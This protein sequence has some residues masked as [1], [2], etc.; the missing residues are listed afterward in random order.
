M[1]VGAYPGTFDPPTVAHVAIAEAAWRQGGLDRVELVVCAS[2]LGKGSSGVAPLADRVRLLDAVCEPR[3]WL[4]WS[5]NDSQLI[6]DIADGYDAVILGSDKWAQVVDPQWYDGSK[7]VR[8]E[9]LRRL[10]RVLIAARGSDVLAR[11]PDTATVLEVDRRLAS[12]SATAVRS[13]RTDWL[14]PELAGG[15]APGAGGPGSAS[16]GGASQGAGRP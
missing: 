12:V 8:D 9:A 3:P 15:W 1:R 2:P 14:A 11:L 4:G 10:P 6:R 7:S 5:V 13:G 16:Q